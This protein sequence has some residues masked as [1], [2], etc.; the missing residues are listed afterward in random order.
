M[1]QVNELA[2]D[3]AERQSKLSSERR[4]AK[5]NSREVDSAEATTK[6]DIDAN[7]QILAEIREIRSEVE[8]LK[9]QQAS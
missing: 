3:H 6:K 4:F 9:R 1:R 8:K 5:V 7:K 2:S